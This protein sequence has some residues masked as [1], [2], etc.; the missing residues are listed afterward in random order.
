[1]I[2]Q[3]DTTK[4]TFERLMQAR[5]FMKRGQELLA[6]ATQ[7]LR[8]NPEA[9]SRLENAILSGRATIELETE[10]IEALALLWAKGEPHAPR[11]DR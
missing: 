9:N 11:T 7:R 5:A 10:V 1:M 8:P 4:R 6:E 2:S 3:F